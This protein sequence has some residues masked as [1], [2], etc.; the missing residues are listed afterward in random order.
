M[1]AMLQGGC[2]L[3][4]PGP[5]DRTGSMYGW[6]LSPSVGCVNS[7]APSVARLQ[8]EQ[9]QVDRRWEPKAKNQPPPPTIRALFQR[10][11]ASQR[12][13]GH[14]PT[15]AQHRSTRHTWFENRSSRSP[16]YCL[17]IQGI[18]S[19]QICSH[20]GPVPALIFDPDPHHSPAIA[21]LGL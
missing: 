14:Q 21:H 20:P 13:Q 16:S 6:R 5:G 12:C 10:L 18:E 2:R 9:Q 1:N 4:P 15:S 11:Q 8:Q 19:L 3:S 17:L 7:R